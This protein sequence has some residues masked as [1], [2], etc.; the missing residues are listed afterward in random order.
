M[1]VKIV[2]VIE[3]KRSYTRILLADATTAC[4]E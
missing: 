1:M 4:S 2:S 3:A